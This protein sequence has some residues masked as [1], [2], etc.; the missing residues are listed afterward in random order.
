MQLLLA[1]NILYFFP[2]KLTVV[3]LSSACR[4]QERA[5]GGLHEEEGGKDTAFFTPRLNLLRIRLSLLPILPSVLQVPLSSL[6]CYPVKLQGNGL[7]GEFWSCPQYRYSS[8]C[9][10]RKELDLRGPPV[11]RADSQGGIKNA[12]IPCFL[13]NPCESVADIIIPLYVM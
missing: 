7:C 6:A 1:L 8:V 12:K 4:G 3:F 13:A 10:S 11:S 5:D 2:L 9:P